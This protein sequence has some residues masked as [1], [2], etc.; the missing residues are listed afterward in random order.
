MA[1]IPYPGIA[2]GFSVRMSGKPGKPGRGELGVYGSERYLLAKLFICA[3]S[4]RIRWQFQPTGARV[5]PY[6]HYRDI[7]L[8][9]KVNQP[10]D[11]TMNERLAAGLLAGISVA[12]IGAETALAAFYGFDPGRILFC[13]ALYVG[14]AGLLFSLK[15]LFDGGGSRIESVSERRVRAMR[16]DAAGRLDGY[17]IDDEFLGRGRS[18]RKPASSGSRPL[19]DEALKAAVTSYASMAGGFEK[20]RETLDQVGEDAF[21]SMARKAGIDGVTKERAMSALT[22]LIAAEGAGR[23][24]EGVPTLSISLDRETFDD[25]IR[26]CMTDKETCQDD[27]EGAGFSIGLDAADLSSRPS[28]PPTDFSH[29]PKAVF[30]KINRPG[31][32]R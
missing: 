25:Y 15:L 12:L 21:R 9:A 18:D 1:R 30:A 4:D 20:L 11:N 28:E 19:D 16:G 14:A 13:L 8:N 24:G 27:D 31:G 32:A 23:E 29:D 10:P 5:K 17:E 22:E 3:L 6:A 7:H 26:R 2:V